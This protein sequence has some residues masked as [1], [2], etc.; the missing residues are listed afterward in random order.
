M[1]SL[2]GGGSESSVE[3][4]EWLEDQ[5]KQNLQ[6]AQGVAS[7][8]Y[9]P[10]YGAEVAA[11]NPMQ[12]AGFQNTADA[13]S[14]FGLSAPSNAMAGMPEAQDFGGGV[15]GY[16]SAPLFE[17]AM[18]RFRDARPAQANLI[19]SFFIDPV[20]GGSTL[21]TFGNVNQMS[22]LGTRDTGGVTADQVFNAPAQSAPSAPAPAYNPIDNSIT[23]IDLG[24]SPDVTSI[25]PSPTGATQQTFY[26]DSQGQLGSPDSFSQQ[27][28]PAQQD[29]SGSSF[30]DM[31]GNGLS[32]IGDLAVDAGT[33]YL[34]SP[35]SGV[36]GMIYEN[37]IKDD[38]PAQNSINTDTFVRNNQ[39]I[40]T[41]SV[42]PILDSIPTVSNPVF[43][44]LPP[45]L[46][47][48]QTTPDFSTLMPAD[49]SP[50]AP[51]IS[52]VTINDFVNSSELSLSGQDYALEQQN[53]QA[54]MD[55][56]QAQ[57]MQDAMTQV[58]VTNI[59]NLTVPDDF[60]QIGSMLDQ[61][62]ASVSPVKSLFE[63]LDQQQTAKDKAKEMEARRQNMFGRM[64]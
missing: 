54:A 23:P 5:A 27:E 44:Q 21:N 16:S 31:I 53:A 56:Q 38:T 14:A 45:S 50:A 12:Q 7:I 36:A 52:P 19:D 37:F 48:A 41:P 18:S 3:I 32:T 24:Y 61:N 58:N 33:A 25:T 59:P 20:S 46:M 47:P 40:T 34:E 51:M 57:A 64:R 17:D 29:D 42:N 43:T 62:Q 26:V 35:M 4:P 28:T 15:M 63:Q 60:Y 13:S 9:T 11:F 49:S 10:Y 30:F 2:F 8:G 1:G 22:G 39:D 55:A 6:R